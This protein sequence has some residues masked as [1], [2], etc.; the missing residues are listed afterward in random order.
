MGEGDIFLLKLEALIDGERNDQLSCESRA[1]Q[2]GIGMMPP[3]F[4]ENLLGMEVG[5]EK[6]FVI[7]MP[8][9]MGEYSGKPLDCTVTILE[10][11]KAVVP[12]INDEFVKTNLPFYRDAEALR[13]SV[14]DRMAKDLRLNYEELKQN[15]ATSE[16]SKRFD[17]KIDDDIYEHMRDTMLNNLR[18][19]AISQGYD[20]NEFVQQQGGEEQVGMAMMM[21]T[22]Q[23]LVEGYALDAV[24][25]HFKLELTD[26]DIDAACRAL[27]PEDPS[28]MRRSMER[29]GYG[30]ALRETS[31]RMKAQRYL[32]E[33]AK[34]IIDENL[35]LM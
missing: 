8:E 6:H 1:Y 2:M 33:Q 20:F 12:E 9:N 32:V 19:M 27:N 25:R 26:E 22:R 11:Q 29:T 18:G 10:F 13:E 30:Y 15:L 34:V 7:D 16:I 31:S 28:T 14:R 21:Q 3:S 5:K 17:G 23:A 35:P 24:F 4:D